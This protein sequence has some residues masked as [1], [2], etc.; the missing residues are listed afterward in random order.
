MNQQDPGHG[1]KTE[2]LEKRRRFDPRR[3]RRSRW[4]VVLAG[5]SVTVQTAAALVQLWDG[6]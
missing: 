4:F 2:G 3:W 5:L 6:R 1:N